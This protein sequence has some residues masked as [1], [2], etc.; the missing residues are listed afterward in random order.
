MCHI[1][2][3]SHGFW[4]AFFR[5]LTHWYIPESYPVAEANEGQVEKCQGERSILHS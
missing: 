2:L 5:R 4:L 1:V 3:P